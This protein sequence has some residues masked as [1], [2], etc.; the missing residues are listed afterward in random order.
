LFNQERYKLTPNKEGV[1]AKK[2]SRVHSWR[3][4]SQGKC[5]GNEGGGKTR[6]TTGE[7]RNV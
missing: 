5:V 7:V 1:K 6:T 4:I 3:K 2:G